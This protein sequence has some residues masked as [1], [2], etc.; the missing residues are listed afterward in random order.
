MN[1]SS[2]TFMNPP[3][4]TLRLVTAGKL[5]NEIA[6]SPAMEFSLNPF[7]KCQLAEDLILRVHRARVA[8]R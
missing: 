6:F 4:I 3:R 5:G 8:S 2:T 1:V 7:A